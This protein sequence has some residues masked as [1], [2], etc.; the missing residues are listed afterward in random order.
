MENQ[1]PTGNLSQAFGQKRE[2]S[3]QASGTNDTGSIRQ[4]T[5]G[6]KVPE[7]TKRIIGMLDMVLRISPVM[8]TM[9]EINT[10]YDKVLKKSVS[11]FRGE[12]CKF[13]KELRKRF[14]IPVVEYSTDREGNVV[15]PDFS[16]NYF[17]LGKKDYDTFANLLKQIPDPTRVDFLATCTSTEYNTFDLVDIR[18]EVAVWRQYPEFEAKVVEKA[19]DVIG[20]MVPL[21]ATEYTREEYIEAYAAASGQSVQVGQAASGVN[22]SQLLGGAK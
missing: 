8:A 13:N 14:I 17:R 6:T 7:P 11:C 15:S 12:C 3:P 1:Q 16:V 18:N 10:H 9:W 5:L 20:L 21:E 2:A 4:F 19:K 22:L